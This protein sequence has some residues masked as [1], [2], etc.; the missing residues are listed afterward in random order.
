MPPFSAHHVL[1]N[2]LAA[3]AI[4]LF[5]AGAVSAALIFGRWIFKGR[6]PSRT[7]TLVQMGVW[8]AFLITAS[9]THI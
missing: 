5:L 6:F 2:T 4:T 7:E 8:A 9:L 3:I 1:A